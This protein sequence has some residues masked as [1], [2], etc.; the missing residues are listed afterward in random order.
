L[1]TLRPEQQAVVAAL[2][3]HDSGV[4]AATTA[5]GKTVVA[6]AMI[7]TAQD[8]YAGS[9]SPQGIIE[10]VGRATSAISFDITG[11]RSA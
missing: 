3:Q 2:S 6:A 10:A 4:L 7:C 11:G 5:F 9:R 1:G 8:Q